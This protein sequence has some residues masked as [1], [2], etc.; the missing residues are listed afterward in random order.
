MA[1]FNRKQRTSSGEAESGP[2]DVVADPV[3]PDG[4]PGVDRDWDRAVDGPFDLSE[5]PD[6][7]GR[8]DLGALRV[9]AAQ[10]MELRLDVDQASNLMVGVTAVIAGSSLQIQAFAAPRTTGLWED[11]RAEIG[12]GIRK[13][14]GTADDGVGVMGTELRGR[15]PAVAQDGRV[16]YAPTRFLGV[17]GPRWFLRGV[18]HGPAASDETQYRALLKYLRQVVVV[19]GDEPK[20]PREVLALTPP[21]SVLEAAVARRAAAQAGQNGGGTSA[22]PA[23]TQP[24]ADGEGS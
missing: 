12:D 7:G 24:S 8:L 23:P 1:L 4:E 5:R 2:E 19:R 22:A 13:A 15:M 14:G 11:L 16:S 18:I 3:V 6:L 21:K 10:G 17:D 9:P 20:P